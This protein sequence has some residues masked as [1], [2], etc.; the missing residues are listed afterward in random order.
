MCSISKNAQVA[1]T[2]GRKRWCWGCLIIRH[3]YLAHFLSH[4]QTYNPAATERHTL[5]KEAGSRHTDFIFVWCMARNGCNLRKLST[6]WNEHSRRNFISCLMG[7]ETILLLWA[8]IFA[9]LF[10]RAIIPTFRVASRIEKEHTLECSLWDPMHYTK[11]NEKNY[12]LS[13][14][15]YV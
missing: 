10:Q 15:C 1:S 9:S 8:S 7:S 6:E 4:E 12:K 11:M 14:W 13:P 3:L 2:F 5:M